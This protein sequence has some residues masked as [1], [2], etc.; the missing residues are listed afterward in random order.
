MYVQSKVFD[1]DEGIEVTGQL[2][3]KTITPVG[4]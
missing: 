4:Q 1:N 3:P 2:P